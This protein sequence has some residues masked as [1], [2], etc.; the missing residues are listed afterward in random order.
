MGLLQ[1]AQAVNLEIR[2]FGDIDAMPVFDDAIR[3]AARLDDADRYRLEP[4]AVVIA[5]GENTDI[6]IE[7]RAA[8]KNADPILV[9]TISLT[10][11]EL[12]HI[13]Q[14]A[15]IAEKGNA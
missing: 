5:D 8:A 11:R 2:D 3:K 13:L 12:R 7:V 9:C 10:I 14:L 1:G 15:E 6:Q 4:N